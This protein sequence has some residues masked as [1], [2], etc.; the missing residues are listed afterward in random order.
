MKQDCSPGYIPSQKLNPTATATE[1]E[2]CLPCPPGYFCDVGTGSVANAQCPAG[3]FC[4]KGQ[5]ILSRRLAFAPGLL[6]EAHDD[7]EC[8]SVSL[9][10]RS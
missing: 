2:C 8:E 7:S 5:S 3:S 4:K 9:L 6:F 10:S 1:E